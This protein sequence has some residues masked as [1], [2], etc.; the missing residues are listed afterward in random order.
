MHRSRLSYIAALCLVATV[1]AC[2]KSSPSA[3]SNATGSAAS[4]SG[5]ATLSGTVIGAVS[6]N[7]L[8][9]Q[10]ASGGGTTISVVGS[11]ATAFVGADGSFALQGVPSGHIEIEIN[12]PN[13]RGRVSLDDVAERE[14][15]RIRI[16]I[17]GGAAEIE[18]DHRSRPDHS[19]EIE[20]RVAETPSP[21]VLPST[22]RIGDIVVTVPTG[23][24]IRHGDTAL[25]FGSIKA[26][27]RVHIRAVNN[28]GILTA[29]EIK[30]QSANSGPGDADDDEDEDDSKDG[31]RSEL[32]GAVVSI[33]A[34]NCPTTLSFV[35]G[36][37]TITANQQTEFEHTS[38]AT[39]AVNDHVEVKGTRP[40]TTTML[41]TK[42][43]KD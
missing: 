6:G 43:E 19:V 3:P 8:T 32:R 37:I 15:I 28:G 40:T 24:P 36:G 12:G 26:G 10:A 42:I 31:D 27:D 7:A 41:A 2:G 4:A 20:G 29:T 38:C 34:R 18:E 33:G 39:L 21:S 23:T 17:S 30:V 22:I 16:R 9:A 35:I 1:A 5:T 13:V 14:E 25:T 11:S